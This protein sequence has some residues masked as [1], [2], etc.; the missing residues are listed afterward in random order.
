M[1][2]HL[3][4]Q[5]EAHAAAAGDLQTVPSELARQIEAHNKETKA[6]SFPPPHPSTCFLV[7]NRMANNGGKGCPAMLRCTAMV[8]GLVSPFSTPPLRPIHCTDL[9]DYAQRRGLGRGRI[10]VVLQDGGPQS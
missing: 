8:S 3:A 1:P 9:A 2:E 6:G 10:D 5:V 4:R 7:W